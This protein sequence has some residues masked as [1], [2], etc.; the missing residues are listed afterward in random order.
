MRLVPALTLTW[1]CAACSGTTTVASG[2]G[3][4]AGAGGEP[5]STAS[6]GGGADAGG[7][8]AGGAPPADCGNGVR[9][10]P[11]E[12][13]DQDDLGAATCADFGMTGQLG[14]TPDCQIDPTACV[15]CGNGFLDEGEV[16]DGELVAGDCVAGADPDWVTHVIED[17]GVEPRAIIDAVKGAPSC[18]AS[19]ELDFSTCSY[20]FDGVISAPETCEL[21]GF[22]EGDTADFGGLTCE[23]YGFGPG[24]LGCGAC[25]VSTEACTV[26]PPPPCLGGNCSLRFQAG[27]LGGYCNCLELPTDPSFTASGALT[28]EYWIRFQGV[29]GSM[30]FGL[31]VPGYVPGFYLHT[32]QSDPDFFA[33]GGLSFGGVSFGAGAPG[34]SGATWRHL[35]GVLDPDTGTA[36]FYVDGVLASENPIEV[37][38]DYD[39]TGQLIRAGWLW[40]DGNPDTMKVDLDEIRISSVARYASDFTP[41]T[42]F[43]PDEDTLGLW[44]LDDNDPV[45]MDSGPLGLHGIMGYGDHGGEWSGEH[46]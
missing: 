3:G 35:A 16:C 14:C 39:F 26:A 30:P 29:A 42:V 20:C 5:T 1:L 21:T 25:N 6:G 15:G 22:G 11:T 37:A 27:W 7:A 9:E 40:A 12:E 34:V 33:F 32:L 24:S 17:V 45:L 31:V 46:P 44:H 23:D 13:C 36:R 18:T 8:S 10:A 38:N 43:S 41:Q 2:G 19:C 28:V 4:E